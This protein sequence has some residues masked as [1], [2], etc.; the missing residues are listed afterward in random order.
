MAN[1][2]DS[3]NYPSDEP[4]EFVAGDFVAWKRTDLGAD[5][6]PALYALTYA[7]HHEA[8]GGSPIT[9]TASESGNDYIIEIAATVTAAYTA[10]DYHWQAYITRSSDSARIKIDEG[11]LTILANRAVTTT[12]PRSHAQKVLDA[13]EALIEG[14]ATQDAEEYSIAGRS[15]KKMPVRDLLKFADLYRAKVNAEKRAQRIR[16]GLNGNAG[17]EVRL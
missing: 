4:L 9:L 15:L 11:R 13:L 6:P 8:S 5:Y 12:D 10:D 17:L 1:L 7:L 3:I 2:F 14:R 16:S